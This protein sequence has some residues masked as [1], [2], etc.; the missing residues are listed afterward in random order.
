MDKQ[1]QIEEIARELGE[2]RGY[3]CIKDSRFCIDCLL[4]GDCMPSKYATYLYNAGYR[5]IPENAVVLETSVYESLDIKLYR[6]FIT[7]QVRK[8][9]ADKISDKARN[10]FGQYL[11]KSTLYTQREKDIINACLD[12][13]C[14]FCKEITE[15]KN[16]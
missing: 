16:V 11:K 2:Q 6:D 1:K 8:E 7:E 9:T 3:G 4:H 5:K 10:F 12:K 13:F 15:G 14:D